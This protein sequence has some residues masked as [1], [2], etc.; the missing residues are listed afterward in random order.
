MKTLARWLPLF[1][2]LFLLALPGCGCGGDDDDSADGGT[3]VDDDTSDDDAADDDAADDD[4]AFD[5]DFDD[6]ANDDDTDDD[7]SDDDAGDDDTEP[8]CDFAAHDPL[9]EAGIAALAAYDPGAAQAN[10]DAAL[11]VCPEIA[12]GKMGLL[13]SGLQRVAQGIPA[14]LA[15]LADFPDVDWA[16]LQQDVRDGLLP[17]CADMLA[18]ADD[19]IVAHPGPRL[20]ASP[21]PVWIDGE[22]IIV[23]AGG[24]WD[25]ADVRDVAGLVGFVAGVAD[26]VMSLDLNADWTLLAGTPGG[27]DPIE[28]VHYYAGKL[29]AM[30]ADA[31]YPGFLTF[32]PGGE[33]D[34]AAAA[35]AIGH[36]ST[37]LFDGL[38]AVRAETDPQT[39]DVTAYVDENGDGA[40]TDGEV[41]RIPYMGVLSPRQNSVIE[42]AMILFEDLGPALLDAGPEDIDPLWPNWLPLDDLNFILDLFTSYVPM[43]DLP[44]VPFPVGFWFYN[45]PADGLRGVAEALAQAL[46]DVTMP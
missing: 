5:D 21:M 33:A 26:V 44:P 27:Y 17:I 4:T 18:I 15:A 40:W 9:V 41:Y 19:L 35:I 11:A 24:E 31:S 23:D 25:V 20:F 1:A 6:D 22:H 32:A 16:V 28:Y 29:L 10:F 34:F 7:A 37:S 46:Y 2:F 39:D 38:T 36:A 12:D 3:G 42:N 45:P 30:F 43:P 8:V 13:L 14:S